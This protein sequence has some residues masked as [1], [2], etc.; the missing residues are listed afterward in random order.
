MSSQPENRKGLLVLTCLM[1]IHLKARASKVS[2]PRE[3]EDHPEPASGALAVQMPKGY[4]HKQQ[5]HHRKSLSGKPGY[6]K[7]STERL[8]G[9]LAEI[10]VTRTNLPNTE[11][12]TVSN[13]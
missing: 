8:T 9:D 7:R 1:P 11:P 3:H 10:H 6:C 5:K 12:T 13:R 4:I 2:K